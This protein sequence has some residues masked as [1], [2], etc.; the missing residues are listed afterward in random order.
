[1]LKQEREFKRK[2]RKGGKDRK[3]SIKVFKH[4]STE[5]IWLKQEREFNRK[6][7]PPNKTAD[8]RLEGKGRKESIKVFKRS[9]TENI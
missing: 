3:E 1:M 7:R 4:S 9:S 2:D 5:N 6:D 8:L